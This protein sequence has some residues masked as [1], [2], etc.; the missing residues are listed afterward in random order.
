M[1]M[2]MMMMMPVMP[3]RLEDLK[4]TPEDTERIARLSGATLKQVGSIAAIDAQLLYAAP[5]HLVCTISGYRQ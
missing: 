2:M 1:M 3:A 4:I 5:S